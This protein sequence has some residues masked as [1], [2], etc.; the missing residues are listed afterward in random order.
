MLTIRF[1][2]YAAIAK[3]LSFAITLYQIT[4]DN[5]L[6][7]KYPNTIEASTAPSQ[8]LKSGLSENKLSHVSAHRAA[9]KA[10]RALT[11]V[12]ELG[13]IEPPSYISIFNFIQ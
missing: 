11:V 7:I 9:F 8:Q 5:V 4:S 6:S 12:V 2:P 3:S 13:G 1:Y 10:L